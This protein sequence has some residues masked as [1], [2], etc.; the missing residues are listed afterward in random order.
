MKAK[1]IF[2]ILLVLVMAF[3]FAACGNGGDGNT[4][5][6]DNTGDGEKFTIY[7]ITMDRM[8]AHW[9]AVDEGCKA[10]VA[11]IGADKIDYKWDGPESKDDAGQIE[12]I[13]NAVSAGADMILLAAKSADAQVAAIE[14]ASA[15]GVQFIYVDSPANW[16]GAIMTIKTDNEAAGKQAGEKM[17]EKLTADGVTS[18]DIGI[19][20]VDAQ[21][22]S[23]AAREAGFRA[24]FDGSDFTILETQYCDGLADV[25]QQKAE[26]FI[27]QGVVGIYGTN[28]GSTV[29]VGNAIKEAGGDVVGVGFDTGGSVPDLVKEGVLLCTMA[30]EPYQMGYQ[31]MKA[32]YD[33]LANGT[34][35]AT[36][37][38]DSGATAKGASDF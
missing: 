24:A 28:E 6:D 13:N 3:S 37:D 14:E 8:D 4:G 25:A 5:G 33:Y 23:T 21:T 29:G 31:G 17:L 1:R 30:Q 7:L 11:E 9:A 12:C 35:P 22:A 26:A 20:N 19:V 32:A 34:E 38:V 36:K 27:T 15:K 10:A 2:A 16:D 18:G